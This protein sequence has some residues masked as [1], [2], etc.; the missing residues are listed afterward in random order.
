[1]R[2]PRA[3]RP[4][5]PGTTW[6]PGTYLYHSGSHPAVQVQ[7]GL[8]GALTKLSSAAN[9]AYPAVATHN[10]EAT[11][12]FS[13]VDPVLHDA[14]ATGNYGPGLAVSSTTGYRARYFLING[15]SYTN[16]FETNGLAHVL[17]GN[18]PNNNAQQNVL[19]RFLNASLDSHVPI[20]NGEYLK[21]IAEDGKPY[22]Y[23]QNS[24]APQLPSLKTLDA[25][26]LPTR[27]GTFPL[28]DRRLDLVNNAAAPGGMLTYLAVSKT[29][30]NGAA[31]AIPPNG[32]GQPY[33]PQHHRLGFAG[34]GQ[35]GLGQTQWLPPSPA[36]DVDILLTGP[37]GQ[38]VVH[39]RC[40]WHHG[41]SQRQPG[42]ADV[43]RRCHREFDLGPV[44]DRHLQADQ[45][46]GSG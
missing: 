14:V 29:I 42:H 45:P 10:S 16:G 28:Y 11:L 30:N 1:M 23:S 3:A 27:A 21:L 37:G 5:T 32:S 36:Q 46:G 18:I 15:Q 43:R 33:P 35:Q 19:L 22:K 39:V 2:R 24:C 13:E 8:Y 9:R 38:R 34:R 6:H 26:W 44:G 4:F 25:F 12:L 17:A 40:R 20:L 41:H 31:I 7:M